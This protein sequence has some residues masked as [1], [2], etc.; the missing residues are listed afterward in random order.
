[1]DEIK[2]DSDEVESL[3]SQM[4]AG[5]DSFSL[6]AVD[7]GSA[8]EITCNA[9]G[10]VSYSKCLKE[11]KSILSIYKLLVSMDISQISKSKDMLVELD[12][13]LGDSFD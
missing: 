10:L 8:C 13:Q 1:M 7:I 12:E 11:I 5:V 4:K 2:V 6:D 3:I 9:D